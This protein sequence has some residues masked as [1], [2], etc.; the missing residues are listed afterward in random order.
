MMFILCAL[1]F[2]SNY[3]KGGFIAKKKK[4]KTA[5]TIIWRIIIGC[6]DNIL[7]YNFKAIYVGDFHFLEYIRELENIFNIEILICY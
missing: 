4:K 7:F 1:A 3:S 5:N 6:S 2:I